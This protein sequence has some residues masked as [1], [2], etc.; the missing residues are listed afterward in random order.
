MNKLRAAYD[1]LNAFFKPVATWLERH[2]M[3]MTSHIVDKAAG[4]LFLQ[5]TAM[6]LVVSV[7]AGAALGAPAAIAVAVIAPPAGLAA[8]V[9]FFAG[10]EKIENTFAKR[11]TKTVINLAGQTVHGTAYDLDRLKSYETRISYLS[12]A[13][14]SAEKFESL[15]RESGDP[16]ARLKDLF[17]KAAPHAA[18]VLV[19][20]DP[21][22]V[23]GTAPA[24]A[25]AQ[26][27]AG[28]DITIKRL[29]PPGAA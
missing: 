3:P 10:N 28:T 21:E 17:A 25:F 26:K 18:R 27:Q 22:G 1:R 15:F 20:H 9:A 5:N 19:V 23:E 11:R 16:A 12:G 29:N 4:G 7:M 13:A 24:Y 2:D 8:I 14:E 6:S